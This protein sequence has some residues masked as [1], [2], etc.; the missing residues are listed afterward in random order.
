MISKFQLVFLFAI[1]SICTISAQ[2][3]NFQIDTVIVF[4]PETK[5]EEVTIVKRVNEKAIALGDVSV[6]IDTVTT[7]DAE[8][9]YD[10][11]V[12]VVKNYHD[13]ATGKSM[14]IKK[15]YGP[16][17]KLV[18]V[19]DTIITFYPD[20]YEERIEYVKRQEIKTKD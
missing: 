6:S 5:T 17:S 1:T 18:T 11:S 15:D 10:S 4:D 9:P 7:F 8:S 2:T 19:I 14:S 16:G 13:K 20:T 12:T 3:D